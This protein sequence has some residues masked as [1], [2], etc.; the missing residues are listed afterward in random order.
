LNNPNIDINNPASWGDISKVKQYIKNL[1]EVK[2]Q[3]AGINFTFPFWITKQNKSQA[4]FI[5]D[6]LNKQGYTLNGRNGRKIE[7]EDITFNIP[8]I[9][10]YDNNYRDKP[11]RKI[12]NTYSPSYEVKI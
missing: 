11:E 7:I 3:P 2:I 8:T 1:N 10:D 5:A 6:Q 4:P 12:L 9:L